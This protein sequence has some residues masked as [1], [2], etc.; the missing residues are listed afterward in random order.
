M[1]PGVM[2]AAFSAAI[3][4]ILSPSTAVCSNESGVITATS[5]VSKTFV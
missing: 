2:I 3:C 4:S 1:Q 5:F